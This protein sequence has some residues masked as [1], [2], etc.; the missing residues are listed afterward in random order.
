M[1]IHEKGYRSSR[2][3][4]LK[5][6]PQKIHP[7]CSWEKLLLSVIELASSS[8][9]ISAGSSSRDLLMIKDLSSSRLENRMLDSTKE[10][11]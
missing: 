3:K 7:L 1:N 2:S 9:K 8:F 4:D 6:V 5:Q 10:L 11:L